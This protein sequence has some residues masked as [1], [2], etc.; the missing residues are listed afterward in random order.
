MNEEH[1]IYLILKYEPIRLYNG[2][3]VQLKDVYVFKIKLKYIYIYS[4]KLH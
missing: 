2:N 1:Q 3:A 4:D